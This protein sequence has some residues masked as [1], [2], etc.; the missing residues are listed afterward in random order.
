MLII[1]HLL[2]WQSQGS[3][4]WSWNYKLCHYSCNSYQPLLL[5]QFIFK[6]LINQPNNIPVLF[7][8]ILPNHSDTLTNTFNIFPV[9][10]FPAIHEVN[11][12]SM[13]QIYLLSERR[14][15]DLTCMH[16]NFRRL[17]FSCNSC[18]RY[19]PVKNTSPSIFIHP[20][21]DET[22]IFNKIHALIITLIVRYIDCEYDVTSS[23]K[24]NLW[25][26]PHQHNSITPWRFKTSRPLYAITVRHTMIKFVKDCCPSQ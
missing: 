15:Q 22:W 5:I 25:M 26:L 14:S 11:S 1:S 6:A 8:M 23:E 24:Q 17:K 21:Y 18:I 16:E 4:L 2:V 12:G 20:R 9:L 13:Y 19:W 7:V 10:M 3:P